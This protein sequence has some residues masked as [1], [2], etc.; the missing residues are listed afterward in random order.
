MHTHVSVY[1]HTNV[2]S[3]TCTLELHPHDLFPDY[4]VPKQLQLNTTKKTQSNKTLEIA[5]AINNQ[6]ILGETIYL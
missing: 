5:V 6:P 2:C 3:N 4:S 1:N